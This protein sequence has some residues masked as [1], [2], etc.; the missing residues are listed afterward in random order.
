MNL[1]VM[2]VRCEGLIPESQN[3]IIYKWSDKKNSKLYNIF[4]SLFVINRL[5]FKFIILEWIC[6]KK[7]L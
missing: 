6:K 2:S 1:I 7:I 4:I 3:N 5:N